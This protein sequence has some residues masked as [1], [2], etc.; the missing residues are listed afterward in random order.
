MKHTIKFSTNFVNT[1][2]SIL[3]SEYSETT[4][5]EAFFKLFYLIDFYSTYEKD[6]EYAS[7][8]HSTID[9]FLGRIKI[10]GKEIHLNTVTITKSIEYNIISYTN[11]HF[12]GVGKINNY[13]RKYKFTDYFKYKYDETFSEIE[14]NE[15]S[16][17]IIRKIY[18]RPTDKYLIPQYDLLKSNRISFDYFAANKWVNDNNIDWSENKDKAIR[19]M[20]LDWSDKNILVESSEKSNRVFTNVTLMKRELR[21]YVKIDGEEMVG[22]DLKSAQPYLLSNRL[23]NEDNSNVDYLNFY[24]YICFDDIYNMFYNEWIILNGSSKYMEYNI[25]TQETE[26][27]DI[28]V[29]NQDGSLNVDKTRDNS[30]KQF[31]RLMYKKS[32]GSV[33][34]QVILK[35]KFPDVYT[36]LQEIK[37]ELQKK[38]GNDY[39]LATDLQK[40][41][42]SIF[43][44]FIN[45]WIKKGVLSCHDSIYVKKNEADQMKEELTNKFKEMGYNNYKLV[46]Q[47]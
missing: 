3:E 47:Q 21:K 24:N 35:N 42:A 17:K 6:R 46:I 8:H 28:S 23:I 16:S 31:M 22:I 1:I 13:T 40:E 4:P 34:Y 7:L 2:D 19:R 45:K 25:D 26:L 20:I 18:E 44:P 15:S 12:D 5:R 27:K 9:K 11:H 32:Y 37:N 36:R 14:I 10:N 41:E 38:H 33:P 43:I 30:K 29:Y 39:N